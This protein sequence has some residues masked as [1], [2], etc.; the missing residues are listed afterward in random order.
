MKNLENRL[1]A[2]RV[3]IAKTKAFTGARQKNLQ[4]NKI[5]SFNK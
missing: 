4:D 3:R 1:L 2:I 5:E